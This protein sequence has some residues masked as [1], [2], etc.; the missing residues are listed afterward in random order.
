MKRGLLMIAALVA[1]V[2]CDKAA[3]AAVVVD[4]LPAGVV[5]LISAG[6]EPR[7]AL[8][9]QVAKGTRGTLDMT[10]KIALAA[11]G[12]AVPAL[13]PIR[14]AMDEECLDVDATGAMRFEVRVASMTSDGTGQMAA[15]MTMV[16]DMMKNM[17][18]RFRLS[19]SGKVD[20]VVVEGLSGPMAELGTQMKDSIEQFAAPL[21]DE[22]IGKGATWRFKRAGAA[23]G[24]DVATVNQYEL[25]ALD[26]QVATF[27]VDGRVVAPSQTF[28][29]MGASV[30]LVKM[31]GKVTGMVTNDLGKYAPTGTF[32]VTM[33]LTV[34]TQGKKLTMHTTIE[35]ELSAR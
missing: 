20:E 24:V 11:K 10:I 6:G 17:V 5:Q 31:E 12:M 13:P 18:Y 22:P 16:R 27:K 1:A 7:T 33:D 9:Y 29:R 8:R 14:M 2:G 25:I 28:D 15:L 21:P 23:N 30:D 35:S 19:P 3:P 26:G 4:D 32:A 34:R